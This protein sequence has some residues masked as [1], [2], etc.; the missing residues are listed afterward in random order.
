[1]LRK[2]KIT[3]ID[4]KGRKKEV[5]IEATSKY[6]AKLRFY[7]INEEHLNSDIDKIEEVEI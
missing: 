5:V 4:P 3:F 7:R 6:D 1:M 2:F